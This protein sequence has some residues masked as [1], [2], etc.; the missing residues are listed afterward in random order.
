MAL[1]STDERVLKLEH[2]LK[3]SN[4]Q[5][6][7]LE[8]S[9]KDKQNEINRLSDYI[10]RLEQWFRT[11]KTWILERKLMKDFECYIENETREL[12]R[13]EIEYEEQGFERG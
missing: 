13:E 8:Q 3:Q 5:C 6:H 4:S 11:I 2:K 1:A 7:K 9:V 12:V 10:Q